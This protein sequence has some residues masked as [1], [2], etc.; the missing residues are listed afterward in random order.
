MNS[1]CI[2]DMNNECM[3]GMDKCLDKYISK[4]AADLYSQVE[5]TSFGP[6][7]KP[8]IE[9]YIIPEPVKV[10]VD[11]PKKSLYHPFQL[12]IRYLDDN[13]IHPLSPIVSSDLEL[14][15]VDSPESGMYNHLF[16]PEH[17]FAKN[18]IQEWKTHYSTNIPFLQDSQSIIQQFDVYKYKMSD[19][20]YQV[21]CSKI[22]AIWKDTKEDKHFLEQYSYMD[23]EMLEYLNH[24]TPFLQ[25]LSFANI[26]SP[27][28]SLIVP[29][30]FLIFPFIILKIQKI[31]ITFSVYLDTLKSIAKNHFI[32]KTLM[33]MQSMSWDKIIYVFITFGLYVMQIYQNINS[34]IRFYQNVQKVNGQ[35]Q[36]M[37]E[38]LDYSIQSIE[39]FIECYSDKV[40][41]KR[42][43]ESAEKQLIGLK[44]LHLELESISPFSHSLGK[45]KDIGYMLRCYYQLYS[46][47]EYADSLQFSF[48]FEGY[49]NNLLGV[50]TN[51]GKNKI[52]YATFD[53]E[54][55]T[56]FKSQYYPLYKDG[57]YVVNDCSFGK[58]IIL[59]A[60]NSGGKTTL[61]KTT[62]IN[63]I[64]SQQVGCGFYT[65]CSLNPYTHIH[66]YINIPDTGGSRDSLFQAESRRCKEILDIISSSDATTSRHF[67][68]LDELF[69]ATNYNDAVKSS[70]SFLV[71]LTNIKNVNF[72]LTT[73]NVSVCK[74]LKKIKSVCNYK[75]D[76]KQNG[77]KLIY[78]YKMKKGISR[79]NGGIHILRDMNYPEEI[80]NSVKNFQ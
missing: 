59:S 14:T 8:Y 11:E 52:A 34:C 69:S 43:I 2:G 45:F 27:L 70:Y 51:L 5:H 76:V 32:G 71:Y 22:M 47:Q 77:D 46:N 72:M 62:T 18:M 79:I 63:I 48:G 58:N 4:T 19:S 29:V 39:T 24:S 53:Q 17:A 49:I 67:C 28:M 12:P 66:S 16:L 44:K 75:M 65:S 40:S 78:T 26:T 33:N 3:N 41:Y 35:L 50:Y 9:K 64:F 74:K 61:L 60:P 13:C 6:I 68:I 25:I 10:A 55:D 73:H 37:R 30:L 80:L 20:T 1:E 56:E 54:K 36:E 7:L 31:P 23:W 57:E 42:F 21:D 15:I 38:Y